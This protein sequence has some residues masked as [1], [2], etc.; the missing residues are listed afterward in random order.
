MQ[1]LKL[2]PLLTPKRPGPSQIFL[3]DNSLPEKFWQVVNEGNV[4]SITYYDTALG[5]KAS[6]TVVY[7]REDIDTHFITSDFFIFD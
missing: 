2:T 1:K 6:Y 5:M 3:N 4:D 7:K